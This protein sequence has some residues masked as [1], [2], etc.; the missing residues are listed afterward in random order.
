MIKQDFER[1][2]QNLWSNID[3]EKER[4]QKVKKKRIKEG[5]RSYGFHRIL[6]FWLEKKNKGKKGNFQGTESNYGVKE[7]IFIALYH[8]L[9]KWKIIRFKSVWL[10]PKG[11]A[12]KTSID[13]MIYFNIRRKLSVIR[14]YTLFFSLAENRF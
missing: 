3:M 11:Q 2:R 10:V 1:Y 5:I 13:F 4:K 8:R 7:Y 6:P 14:C 9:S 12:N